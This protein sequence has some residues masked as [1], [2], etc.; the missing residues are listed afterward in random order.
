MRNSTALSMAFAAC[1]LLTGFSAPA[2]TWLETHPALIDASDRTPTPDAQADKTAALRDADYREAR[3]RPDH[4]LNRNRYAK[5]DD[6]SLNHP[7][8]AG[9]ESNRHE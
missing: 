1:I 5:A 6:G 9:G 8:N 4:D 7:K 2:Q 3:T